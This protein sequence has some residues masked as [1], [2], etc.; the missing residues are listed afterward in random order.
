MLLQDHG[1][2]V[3]LGPFNVRI[4]TRYQPLAVQ[5][6]SLYRHYRLVP[7]EIAEFHVRVV[8][9][10]SLGNGFKPQVR[11]LIDGQS[12]FESFPEDQALAVMEWG[13]NLAIAVR[14]N[15][16]LLLHSAV[17]EKN[18]HAMLFPAWPGS[19][20]TTLCTALSYN[21]FRLFSDEFG[22]M[23]PN[24]NCFYPIPRLMPLKNK[25]IPII[26]QFLP[27]AVIGQSI[28]NTHKGTV[29]HICPP[30]ASIRQS[31]N[32]AKAR[33][34][35]FPKWVAQTETRL[36]AVS[37]AEAFMLLASNAF[38]Y[39]VIGATGFR[40]VAHLI[41][42]CDCYNLIYSDL[43]DVTQKLHSLVDES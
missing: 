37:A 39:E 8:T 19:G 26:R 28:P 11:V 40:A 43:N 20:K 25:S 10:R 31:D 42:T 2:K 23:D 22:L 33:W 13:I 35:V 9:T 4:Q 16:L 30:E 21:G 29:A 36:E 27:D 18:G 32:P 1:L 7:D 38:N 3:R 15:H 34:V 12:P 24:Q 41:S 5:L 14:V 17:V 6:Y